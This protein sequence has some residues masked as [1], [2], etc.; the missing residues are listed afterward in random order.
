VDRITRGTRRRRDNRARTERGT[1]IVEAAIVIPLLLTVL[2][3]IIEFGFAYNDYLAVRSAA[4]EG[5][6]LAAVDNSCVGGAAAACGSASAQRDKL[7]ADTLKKV[8]GLSSADNVSISVWLPDGSTSVGKD[9]AVTLSVPM[10]SRT[11]LFAPFIN[12]ITL[13]ATARMRLEQKATFTAGSTCSDVNGT[14]A[15]SGPAPAC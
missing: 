8:S 1:T 12:P 7:L 3:G 9:V 2:F 6:R 13:K 4:R 5:A 15:A 14:T 10:K 11:G